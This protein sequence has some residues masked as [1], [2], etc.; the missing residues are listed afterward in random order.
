[1]AKKSTAD[2]GGISHILRLAAVSLV[3]MILIGSNSITSAYMSTIGPAI[4]TERALSISAASSNSFQMA[5]EESLGFFDDTPEDEWLLKKQ[6]SKSRVHIKYEGDDAKK[7]Y[8]HNWY[9]DFACGMEDFVG[10]GGDGGKWICDPHRV[11]KPGCLVYSIGSNNKFDFELAVQ[12]TMPHCEVHIFDFDD[13]SSSMKKWGLVNASYHAWGLKGNDD[14]INVKGA[15]RHKT[16]KSIKQTVTELGHV[17][18]MVD[19]FK[20]DCEGCEWNSYT[21]WFDDAG[22]DLRQILVE[23]HYSPPETNPFFWYLHNLGYA[24]FH[25]EANIMFG[26]GQCVEFSF[27]KLNTTFFQ[28]TDLSAKQ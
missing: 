25:K 2:S 26:G 15:N 22:I 17:G 27:L 9:P 10:P 1:M 24:M 20:I 7:T 5:Y 13:Y 8:A 16:F 23:T 3:G 4:I 11:N 12:N 21:D 28:S 14:S 6:I 18:R 19:I